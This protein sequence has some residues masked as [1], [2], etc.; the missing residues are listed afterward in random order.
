[1][2]ESSFPHNLCMQRAGRLIGKLKLSN[3]V[4]DPEARARG[5]WAVAAGKKIAEHTR[6]T[7]LVRNKLIVEVEDMVWQ[8]Q[9]NTLRQF[10]LRNLTKALGE[11]LV[12][13]LDFRPAPKRRPVQREETPTQIEG[14]HDPVLGLLYQQSKKRGTA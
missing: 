11:E 9:L 8:M 7:A 3:A 2:L 5:A 1:M 14:I 4:A 12:T 6:A 13:E 10:L